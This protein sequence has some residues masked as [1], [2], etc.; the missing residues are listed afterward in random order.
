MNC[1][2]HWVP[3]RT[4]K[5]TQKK[6]LTFLSLILVLRNIPILT[7]TQCTLSFTLQSTSTP[8]ISFL[9]TICPR[10]S[11]YMSQN[12]TLLPVVIIP[13]CQDRALVV[14][15]YQT[16]YAIKTTCTNNRKFIIINWSKPLLTILLNL[17]HGPQGERVVTN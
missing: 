3:L 4:S 15:G 11:C 14:V 1:L 13:R 16:D 17:H 6:F 12:P 7:K 9:L 8:F 2:V 10:K 5:R